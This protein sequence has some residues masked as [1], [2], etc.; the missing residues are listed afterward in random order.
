MESTVSNHSDAV[1]QTINFGAFVRHDTSGTYNTLLEGFESPTLH[2]RCISTEN[3][4]LGT[5]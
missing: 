1:L 5:C 3:R 4:V 2:L